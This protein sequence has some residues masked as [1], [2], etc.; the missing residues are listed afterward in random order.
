MPSDSSSSTDLKVVSIRKNLTL[1]ICLGALFIGTAALAQ[2]G[3]DGSHSSGPST[4][5]AVGVAPWGPVPTKKKSIINM[6]PWLLPFFNN[7]PVFGIPGTETGNLWRR[8]QLTGDWGGSRTTLAEH[9]LFL[10]AYATSTY[11][12]V[13]SGGLQT[14]SAFVQ[15]IQLSVNLDTARAGLWSGGLLHFTTQSRYGTSPANTFTVG[16]VLPQ[17]MGL[18]L[19]GPQFANNTYPSEYFLL[20]AL[21][22]KISVVVGKI[23]DIYL[24]D[25]TLFGNSYKYDFA[26]FNFLKNPMTANF[27]NAT[28]LTALVSWK[29]TKSVVIRAALVDPDS[30][31]NNFAA[32]AFDG[33]NIFLTSILSYDIKGLPGQATPSYNWSN[34]PKIDLESPFVAVPPARR[35]QAVAA[36]LGLAPTDG[37]ETNFNNT[38][39]FAITN[40]SQYLF[41]KDDSAA[42]SEKLKS[43]QLLRG[44]GVFGRA[45]Y[46]P[47]A[48]N[49][50]A[51]DASVALF[52]HGIFDGR[53]YDSFG[54]GFYYNGISSHLKS[55]ITQL[56]AG[57]SAAKNEKGTEVFYNFALTP[58][59]SL[60]PGYQYIWNPLTAVVVDQQ[61][62]ANVF[63]LRSTLTF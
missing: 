24:P 48:S 55:A 34:K 33:V 17:Y 15:N 9:G 44:I 27:F 57:T 58:A 35:P 23:S 52:A 41:V 36:L 6:E 14:G 61:H 12:N 22:E 37:L 30:Q 53:K 40:A 54:A 19:P 3:P 42:V 63:L 31:P 25:Q 5:A 21:T 32:H 47:A 26:N 46:A 51:R 8:T 29:P 38:S 13:M 2:N 20:Q 60:I 11:Q 7:G 45:G 28:S 43:G 56:T 59:F 4:G 18:V 16:S 10:D 1:G 39:W 49:T 62:R 50:L